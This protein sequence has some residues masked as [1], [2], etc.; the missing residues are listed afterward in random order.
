[1]SYDYIEAGFDGFLS[2]SIDDTSQINLD[3]TGPQG[4]SQ[5][6]DRTQVSGLLG[7]T[8]RMGSISMVGKEGSL[9]VTDDSNKRVLVGNQTDGSQGITV[10]KP[11]YDADILRPD[12]LV[13]NSNQNVLKIVV[14][15][16]YTFSGYSSIA[17]SNVETQNNL[18]F[19]GLGYVPA[20]ALFVKIRNSGAGVYMNFPSYYYVNVDN[21]LEFGDSTHSQMVNNIYLGIDEKYLYA[22][23]T[24]F[25]GDGSNPHGASPVEIK[26]YILQESAT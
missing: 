24:A 10:S 22:T 4:R 18:I 15:D 20:Y 3:S 5:A 25:N 9:L 8:L 11:G 2:R 6:Y 13:F 17:A 1:M 16:T 12:T 19:H 23:R 21:Q 26:Y 7:D 14:S